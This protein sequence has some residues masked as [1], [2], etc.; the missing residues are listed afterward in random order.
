MEGNDVWVANLPVDLDFGRQFEFR[1]GLSQSL[2]R[3]YFEGQG[4]LSLFTIVINTLNF[5]SFC[6]T[7]LCRI[8][9]MDLTYFAEEATSTILDHLFC[10]VDSC[11][12]L[13]LNSLFND[14]WTSDCIC[15]LLS[16]IDCF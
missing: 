7:S 12:G 16:Q 10:S 15:Q 14:L 1:F 13:W 4:L 3:D 6:E 2:L 9:L 8:E 5:V 11:G